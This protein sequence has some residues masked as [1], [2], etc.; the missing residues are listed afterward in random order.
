MSRRADIVGIFMHEDSIVRLFG[1]VLPK[2]NDAWQLQH[3][4]L[5]IEGMAELDAPAAEA[6]NLIPAQRRMIVDATPPPGSSTSLADVTREIGFSAGF[7]T[8][9]CK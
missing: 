3:R 6:Q 1:T 7:C 9:P 5:Q 8:V 2:V 4:Y